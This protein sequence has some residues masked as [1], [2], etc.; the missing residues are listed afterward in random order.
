MALKVEYV[1]HSHSIEFYNKKTGKAHWMRF[2]TKVSF[3]ENDS[4]KEATD[5]AV[6]VVRDAFREYAVPE[7]LIPVSQT[8]ETIRK[9]IPDSKIMKQ[10]LE[11]VEKGDEATITM[12]SNIYDI[13]G[14]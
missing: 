4:Y 8:S 1:G 7:D 2:D 14:D 9:S 13:K 6:S 12:L 5:K 10:F 3:D 11:A